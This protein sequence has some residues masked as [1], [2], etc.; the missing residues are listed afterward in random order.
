MALIAVTGGTGTL[1]QNLVPAALAR[2]HE[3]RVLSRRPGASVTGAAGLAV[4]APSW[5]NC[6]GRSPAVG[7]AAGGASACSAGYPVTG[8]LDE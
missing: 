8:P 1:G 2:G 3:V 4:A 7:L 5:R 6:S